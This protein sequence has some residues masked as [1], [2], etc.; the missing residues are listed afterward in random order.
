MSHLRLGPH[1]ALAWLPSGVAGVRLGLRW[2]AH[3]TGLPL[4]VVAAIALVLSWRLFKRGARF[5]VEV[6]FAVGLLAAATRFG[7]V[8]W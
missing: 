6:A 8:T 3:H 5:A 2:A 1:G 4:I 7:W